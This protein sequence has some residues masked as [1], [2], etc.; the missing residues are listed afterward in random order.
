MMLKKLSVQGFKSFADK[1]EFEFDR[2]VTCIVG[3]NGCGKSN[4]VDAIK[5]VLG[6]QSA[7]SLR[8][9]QMQDVIFNGSGTRKGSGM[10][11]VD[12]TFDN[13]DRKLSV[14]AEEVT[15]TR[16]LFRDGTS[17]YVV[18]N[19]DVRLKDI[20]EM[21]MDTG[22][23]FDAYSIIEQGRIEALLQANPLERRR[24][25]RRGRRHQQVPP[26]RQGGP[27][28]TRTNR[29]EPPPRQR[30]PRGT[31][32]AP[33]EREGPGR[34]GEVL[35]GIH[36]PAEGAAVAVRAQR[37]S[38]VLD[39]TR[40]AQEGPQDR[41]RAVDGRAQ[42]DRRARRRRRDHRRQHRP[43]RLANQRR[44]KRPADRS[45][46]GQYP[47]RTHQPDPPPHAGEPGNPGQ[48]PADGAGGAG[49]APSAR[50]KGRRPAAAPGRTG[51]GI[52][53]DEVP[54]RRDAGRGPQRS[55]GDQQYRPPSGIGQEPGARPGAADQPSPQRAGAG[56]GPGAV[57]SRSGGAWRTGSPTPV[58]RR[59]PSVNAAEPSSS[60]SRTSRRG[61]PKVRPAS[62]TCRTSA[63]RWTS[64]RPNS[65]AT[66]ANSRNAAAAFS[67]G[68]NCWRNSTAATRASA[69]PS[70]PS[71]PTATTPFAR[72][73]LPTSAACSANSSR[74]TS[75][76]PAGSRARS[77]GSTR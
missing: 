74:P 53:R 58:T 73:P 6:E 49:A 32:Q 40:A 12:L 38:Q 62:R 41:P 51:P 75:R 31:R 56:R 10:A 69:P 29:P 43:T 47:A 7:K 34:P 1:T 44:R 77:P 21:F 2:G 61:R 39:R 33:A 24:A 72:V 22:V 17:E 28:Q 68:C 13:A 60:S 25:V 63:S 42:P 52:N 54:D 70:G 16:R 27:P 35:A 36:G 26:A 45:Q 19:H 65:P 66:W 55:R 8:G 23:G 64:A 15:V 3:P 9:S 18:N 20:R 4:V 5:W 76:T 48:C 57:A 11:Q 50:R 37:I 14:D 59:N 67:A 46:H 71:W 30:H